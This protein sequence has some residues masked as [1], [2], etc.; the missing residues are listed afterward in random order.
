MIH[1]VT[2]ATPGYPWAKA[3]WESILRHCGPLPATIKEPKAALVADTEAAR[4]QFQQIVPY[5]FE[6]TPGC[7]GPIRALPPYPTQR[8][9]VPLPANRTKCMQHGE[10]LKYVVTTTPNDLAIFTDA[11]MLMQRSFTDGE[12]DLFASLGRDE[13][14]IGQNDQ[15]TD[16]L[17]QEAALLKHYEPHS[18]LQL[19]HVYDTLNRA[20]PGWQEC[21]IGNT[22]VVVARIDTWRRLHDLARALLPLCES[23][24]SHYA[25]L[26]FCICYCAGR[27]LRMHR[28]PLTIHTHGHFGVPQ[29]AEWDAAG[30]IC[31]EGVPAVFRHCLNLTPAKGPTP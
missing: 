31:W 15:P 23:L 12:L 22:G 27:W 11:D 10:F 4:K 17:V 16:T 13:I 28:L 21:L 18:A 9:A 6:T 7:N 25:A 24:F 8:F 19:E 2:A 5:F 14:L 1:L 3:Y 29:G 20:L 30:N 26:Q